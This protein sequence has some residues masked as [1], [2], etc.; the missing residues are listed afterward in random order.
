MK[1]FFLLF[2]LILFVILNANSQGWI[3][4][5]STTDSYLTSV[6][7]IN[8]NI[9]FVVGWDGVIL[10]TLD[11]GNHW[12]SQNSN[13]I[14]DLY[15]VYFIDSIT[16]FSTSSHELLK[17]TNGGES[18]FIQ[19]TSINAYLFDIHFPEKDTGFVGGAGYMLKTTDKGEN[20]IKQKSIM[21]SACSFW[22]TGSKNL[23]IGADYG[24][25][26]K[27][28]D[29][30]ENWLETNHT[31][32]PVYI[33][34]IFFINQDTG[35]A[36][37]GGFAQGF[38]KGCVYKTI[39]GG[40]EWSMDVAFSPDARLYSV[41]FVNN[42]IGYIVGNYGSIFK[43]TDA[44]NSWMSLNSNV[45]NSLGSVFFIDSLT[46]YAAGANGTI[47]KTTNGGISTNI[48]GKKETMVN[49][50]PNPVINNVIIETKQSINNGEIFIYDINGVLINKR[51]ILDLITNLDLSIMKS[52]S[53]IIKV[54]SNKNIDI[55]KLVKQ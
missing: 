41:Y 50:F 45:E 43:T 6:Y 44:G 49:L 46:G 26:F 11:G 13:T 19:D 35:Y 47:L 33:D 3:K 9:G 27:S 10:K 51:K 48:T 54:V 22:A 17:T 39:N 37:G 24:W 20:W 12:R 14:N 29:G 15:S 16:G 36:T 23:F 42:K 34:D 5:E 52:G 18:W 21:A 1:R 40:L 7:F 30:G 31:G 28:T 53:Y 8:A 25:I 32:F 55:F 2:E 38:E 4:Q